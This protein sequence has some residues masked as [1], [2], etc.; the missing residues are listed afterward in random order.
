ME[1]IKNYLPRTEFE[2]YEDFKE[3]FKIE[4]PDDFD[5][6]RDIVDKWAEYEP[7]K[8]ALVYCNDDG[9]E[10][11]FSFLELAGLS[12][13]ATAYFISL[14]IKPGDRI[15]TLLRRRYEYWICAIAMARIGAVTVPASIQLTEKDIVYRVNTAKAKL[16]IALND[17]FVLEQIKNSKE[18]CPSII[19][20]L[21]VGDEPQKQY[22]DFNREYIKYD[23][24]NDYSG[25]AN[26]D[27]MIIYFTS[28]TSGYPKMAIH[29][30]TYPLGHIVTAKYMQC[31]QNNGLHLTQSDSGWAKFG[32]GNIYGQWICGSAIFAYDPVRFDSHSLMKAL[33]RF[34]P[35]SLCIPPT[36][37]RFLLRDGIEKKH[38]ESIH[39]FSTAGEPLSGEVNSE[40]HKI[41]GHYIHEGF[42]QSE[43]TPIACA[44]P[45]I[46]VRPSSMGKASPLYNVA[47][48]RPDGR[49]CDQGEEGEVV[50]FTTCKNQLGLLSAYY[51][52][53]E[54][55]NP[56]Q[57]GIYHTGDIAFEDKD[58]YYW[59][60][61][62]NDD[63][64]KCSGYRIG[65]FEIESV[66]NTHPAVRESAII[67]HPDEIRG[68][69]VCAVILLREGYTPSEALTKELQSYVKE[70]TAPYK[71][72]RKIIYVPEMPKTTSGKIIR[73]K[74]RNIITSS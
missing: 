71:Y 25:L 52:N 17:S 30:R 56:V 60:V 16:V 6:A 57:E 23:E 68:Q 42:G 61:G 5:F 32:W 26:N 39:W 37:Y 45:W 49:L 28:G 66:L 13:R 33:E 18:K 14:G 54:M 15:L 19:D 62:R 9:F 29:N 41:S 58:G 74:L 46:P 4:V 3:N 24:W 69:I 1:L 51:A 22:Q 55:I 64:I 59:Y 20:I 21:I 12:K 73:R 11:R 47:L 40:F 34:K 27:E 67:A 8:T 7:D 48:I 38:V 70:N 53:G 2:S 65:P 72:P 31:V 35:T 50:I 43:G 63:M 36:M 44:F 10:R